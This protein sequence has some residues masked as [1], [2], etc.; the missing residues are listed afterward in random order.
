M[1]NAKKKI[2]LFSQNKT[3]ALTPEMGTPAR[4]PHFWKIQMYNT[5]MVKD[6]CRHSPA[7]PTA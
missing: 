5:I 2:A 6:F 4:E 3:I 1:W 7:S